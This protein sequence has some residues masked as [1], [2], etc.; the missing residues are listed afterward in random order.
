MF[1]RHLPRAVIYP[2]LRVF[3]VLGAAVSAAPGGA[4]SAGESGLVL[5]K[6][7]PQIQAG[8]GGQSSGTA[9]LGG[10]AGMGEVSALGGEPGV[11]GNP[12]D[13]GAG[14]GG[15]TTQPP[16]T[17]WIQEACT[18]T[19][20][21]ENR[22]TTAQGQLFTD[23][24]PDPSM[25]VWA[26]AHA[27]CRLLYR[28]AAEV[29]PVPK[30]TLIVEDYDGVAGTAGTT[31]RLSTRYLQSQADRG[32]DLRQE[33]TGILHF[34]TSL[35]FQNSG[36]SADAAPPQWLVVGIADYVRLES[37]YID[38]LERSKGGSYDGSGSRTTAFFLDY[39]AT[40][41]PS[42]IMQLNQR[43]SPTSPAWTNEVFQTLLGSD[44]NSLW[45]AYQASF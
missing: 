42:V 37:G 35:T 40:K 17:A 15:G 14:T 18:P 10:D 20:A 5:G 7:L 38:R 4:C 3:L 45:E 16:D 13:A 12:S 9:A 34:A 28:N 1:Q 33:I 29:K 43:L 24:V 21:F 8:T 30:L 11:S 31:L 39:L 25:P 36:S 32:V 6:P 23:A 26:A 44:V 2:N 41:N 19:L 22:D 27:A